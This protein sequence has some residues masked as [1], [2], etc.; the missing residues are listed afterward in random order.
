[1]FELSGEVYKGRFVSEKYYS[2]AAFEY[3]VYVPKKLVMK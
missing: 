1:M 2:G 3:E